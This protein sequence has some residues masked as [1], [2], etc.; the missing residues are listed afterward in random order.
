MIIIIIIIIIICNHNIMIV[1]DII[2]TSMRVIGAFVNW[3]K[4]LIIPN[5]T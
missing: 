1:I 4:D 3:N 5:G 2:I